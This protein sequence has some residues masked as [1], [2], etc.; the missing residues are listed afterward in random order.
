MLTTILAG[1]FSIFSF[2]MVIAFW[3]SVKLQ[4]AAQLGVDNAQFGRLIAAFQ[5]I[6]MV[7]ALVGGIAIDNFGHR[8]VILAGATL[9]AL[10]IFLIG[11]KKKVTG[12]I[13]LCVPLGIGAQFLNLG[14]NT[15]IPHLFADPSAGSNVGNAF[16][17]LGALLVSLLTAYLFG[18][19]NFGRV[20]T[21]VAA[22]TLLPLAFA[23]TSHFPT[24]ERSFDAALAI[25][26]L[27]NPITWVA[28]L[29]LFCYVG[30]EVSL[31]A[32]ITSYATE[33]GANERQA[34][35]TLSLFLVA[36]MVS[37]LVLGLQDRVTG[38]DL[39]PIGGYVLTGA[40]LLAVVVITAL[41]RTRTLATARGLVFLIG[42]LL[43]PIF[44]TT[45]GITV[46]HFA[47]SA[48]GTLFGV[49][50]A[51]GSL[52]AGTLPAW[53]GS[54]AKDGSV[55]AGFKVLRLASLGLSAI[56]LVLSVLPPL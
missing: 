49:I 24:T 33:L 56:A 13:L 44:P 31:G 36:M 17:G 21:I 34:S 23:L 45:I 8:T 9:P 10:A 3:G 50:F 11:R 1:I 42:F 2:G 22:I 30:V 26:L 5:A 43:G 51:V 14:G 7:M 4:L 19:M 55:Q 37:R 52:G 6:M 27:G 39:T 18:K 35:R 32:W 12:V 29:L 47:P 48:W 28:A 15:L 16:F 41:M 38:I 20:L 40:A 46:Q 25:R 53:L 54:L